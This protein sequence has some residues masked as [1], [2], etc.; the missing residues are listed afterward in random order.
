LAVAGLRWWDRHGASLS[1]QC[2]GS[3]ALEYLFEGGYGFG[4]YHSSYGSRYY[5]ERVS[6]PGFRYGVELARALGVT[7]MR[8]AAAPG[9]PIRPSHYADRIGAF[10]RDAESWRSEGGG[11][12]AGGVNTQELQALAARVAERARQMERVIDAAPGRRSC[13][14]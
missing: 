9:L 6:D 12:P 11:A 3:L 13:A 4:A 1:R 5:M 8:L 7:A 2:A 14:R 10:L